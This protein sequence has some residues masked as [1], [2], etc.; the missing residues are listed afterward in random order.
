MHAFDRRTLTPEIMDEDDVTREE[1]DASLRFI[2]GVNRYLFGTASVVGHFKR[3]AKKWKTGQTIRVLDLATGCADI[4]V[5]LRKWADKA[6]HDVQ[7]VALDR[8]PGTLELAAEYL[9]RFPKERRG[10]ELVRGDA[11]AP[12]FAANSFDY[13]TTSMFLHHLPD[14]EAMT[15]LRV[16][17]KLATRG[18]V[19][20]DLVRSRR[21]YAWCKILTIGWPK[22]VTHDA[23]VSVLAGFRK[24]EAIDLAR[25]VGLDYVRY[26]GH[27]AHRF[28]IGG[29]R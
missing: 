19:W 21:A 13:C 3:F 7:I 8:H 9:D 12:P 10:I 14:I 29:E 24:S 6:G 20:N 1:L 17:D 5:G 11:L 26:R 15:A 25:R 2:R 28:T 4:P 18:I 23:A 16:M 27:L 22:I